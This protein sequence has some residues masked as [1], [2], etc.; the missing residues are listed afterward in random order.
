ME[1]G[2][3][4]NSTEN[5]NLR[6]PSDRMKPV[7]VLHRVLFSLLMINITASIA[8]KL[9]PV[10]FL[11]ER[12]RAML[13]R[14]AISR[15]EKSK[16]C[17][18]LV[19]CFADL[20]PQLSLR[21]PPEHPSIIQ[22][23]FF[24]Y[25]HEDPQTPQ[26]IQYGD[27][28]KSILHSRFN[29]TKHLK[30]LIHGFKGSGS[31]TGMMQAINSL[32]DIEDSN[33]IVLDWTKGAGTSYGNA[34]ANSEL[35]GRQLALILLDVINLG[36]NPLNIH[37]IG[38]SL[39]AHVAGCASEVL[40]KKNLILGR[41]TGLDPASPFFRNHLF[42]EKGRKLDATD[43]LLV[44]VIHT[45][46]S[47]DFADGFGLL[48][49]IGHI[50]FFPNGGR[51]QPGCTDIKNSVVV[52]HLKEELLDRNIACSHLRAWQLFVDTVR[53]QKEDRCKF[54]AWPCPQGGVS[55]ARG[56]CFPMETTDWHQEMGY[57]ADRGPLGIYYLA[58]R[59][60]TP[61]C[62]QPLRASVIISDGMPKTSGILFFKV[63][64]G[65]STT[66]FK[67]QC[68]RRN[69][70][71]TFYNIAA[72]EFDALD[73]NTTA[74]TGIVSYQRNT[75]DKTEEDAAQDVDTDVILLDKLA[76]EDRK[77]HRWEY[78][79][80][81]TAINSHEVYVELQSERCTPL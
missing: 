20:P 61:F 11:A 21:R 50:D 45:D 70:W 75:N 6:R 48:K 78:C 66:L 74:I 59:G 32:F 4:T 73:A 14:I 17:Y 68:T 1:E 69:E 12:N 3:A 38:F 71:M 22:T 79:R 13:R 55:Y 29:A 52:S 31:D 2:W 8:G 51:E 28:L 27:D 18:D 72:A 56:T 76:L 65:N 67:I 46:G 60:E 64:I 30:V 77:G 10:K 62:G 25:T 37:V 42:R 63:L 26:P 80:T 19:G 5:T 40:K 16:I 43:A 34:V 81:N 15:E 57:A 49:P 7:N 58:T 33:V 35:V 39:G 36:I 47:S 54:I 44:D 41:I 24:L 9:Q 23:R 53:T